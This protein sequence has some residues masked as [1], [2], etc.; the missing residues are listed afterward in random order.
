MKHLPKHSS[1]ELQHP[2]YMG[3]ERALGPCITVGSRHSRVENLSPQ[4]SDLLCCVQQQHL[5]YY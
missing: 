2:L 1:S 5:A 3:T 4:E